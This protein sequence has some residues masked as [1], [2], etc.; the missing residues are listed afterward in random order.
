MG[1]V[2]DF[3]DFKVWPVFNVAD[4]SIFCGVVLLAWWMWREEKRERQVR[5]A[6]ADG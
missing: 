2:T 3:L 1:H 6:S 4:T 5:A